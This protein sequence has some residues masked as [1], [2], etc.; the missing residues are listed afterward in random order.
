VTSFG[1]SDRPVILITGAS[2]FVGRHLLPMLEV[3][4]WNVRCAVRASSSLAQEVVVGSIGPQTDW[5]A[6]LEGVDIIIHLAAR[7]HHQHEEYAVKIYRETNVEGT[8]HLARSAAEAGVSQFIFLSTVLVH[9]RSNN[10]RE[11]FS[12]RDALTPRGV[13]GM[14]K[15]EAEAGLEVIAQQG[16]MRVTV[17]RPPLV[18]GSEAKGHFAQLAGAVKRGIPLPFAGIRN[19]RAFLSVE[20]LASFI[21]YRLS[22]VENSFD[23]FLIADQEQISTPEFVE[24]VARAAGTR[25]RQFSLPTPLL[26]SVLAISGRQEMRY[27]LIGSLELDLSK[28][29][30][31]GWQP[32]LTL[33]E[34]LRRALAEPEM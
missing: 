25:S 26:S 13:Y 4:R 19:R 12:E 17:L 23:V 34:G 18:Y 32:S 5:S 33:D 21:L 6:A 1:K 8:L 3:D 27:S 14:S 20:N 30:S 15:A 11:P 10:G 31:T 9:G 29:A 2:G 22:K 28:V 24:R 16:K 7:V